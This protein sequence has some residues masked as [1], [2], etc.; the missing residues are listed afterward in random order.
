MYKIQRQTEVP[1]STINVFN[2]QLKQNE[3]PNLK[4]LEKIF[5]EEEKNEKDVSRLKK[6]ILH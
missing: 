1:A 3:D 6:I 2:Q 4:E 5:N